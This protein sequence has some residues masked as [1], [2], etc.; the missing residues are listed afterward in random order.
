MQPEIS[1]LANVEVNHQEGSYLANGLW[2]YPNAL[3]KRLVNSN[4]LIT[5]ILNS[6][7]N[8]LQRHNDKWQ[9]FSNNNYMLYDNVVICN[10]YQ[11]NSLV[12]FVDCDTYITRGQ[13]TTVNSEFAL[14]TII[15]GDK[16]ILPNINGQLTIGASFKHLITT[17]ANLD[18]RVANISEIINYLPTLN[19][20]IDYTT[21]KDYV[22]LRIHAKDH[23]PIVGPVA[24][25][26]DFNEVYKAL[27]KDSKLRLTDS[28]PYITGLYLNYAF[29]TN[30]MLLAPWCAEL[31]AN[32]IENKDNICSN[33]LK[34]KL[35]PNRF[36]IKKVI[37]NQL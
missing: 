21:I 3:A 37:R 15:C 12:N 32:Y 17:D 35:H 23:M 5:V 29:G 14:K 6:E 16:Y 22:N 36:L 2:F 9:I 8:S 19:N 34:E 25:R 20:S 4:P 18:E 11:L 13:I 28:C 7:V 10:S 31:I 1:R 24:N 30:G 33:N 26:L 27:A